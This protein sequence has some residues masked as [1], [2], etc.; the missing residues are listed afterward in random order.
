MIRSLK[1]IPLSRSWKNL[2]HKEFDKEYMLTLERILVERKNEGALHA[3]ATHNIFAALNHTEPEDVKVVI[4]GQDPYHTKD[5]ATGLA[6]SVASGAQQPPSLR[7]IITEL[8][9]D[10]GIPTTDNGDLS[11]WAGQGV[12]L[13][14]SV[15]TVEVGPEG[16]VHTHRGF[17]WETFTDA[18]I[19]TL[20]SFYGPIVFMLW[21][22]SARK[23]EHLILNPRHRI[24][25]TAHPS[26]HS[27]HKGFFGCKHFSVANEI[28]RRAHKQPINWIIE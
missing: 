22:D 26:P 25:E 21:G 4:V 1:D 10:L 6:F 19:S 17:G 15:L 27:A 14:N 11:S 9:S 18:V 20:N 3:P 23:K 12:L 8:H 2:L 28:L 7:N 13:L 16:A 5:L 24:L